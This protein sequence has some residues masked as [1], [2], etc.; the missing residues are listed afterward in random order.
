M[1]SGVMEVGTALH[2]GLLGWK[3]GKLNEEVWRMGGRKE[4]RA[5]GWG[6]CGTVEGQKMEDVEGKVREVAGWS[7]EMYVDYGVGCS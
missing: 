4:R 6:G 7:L 1:S 2:V 5:G 3:E